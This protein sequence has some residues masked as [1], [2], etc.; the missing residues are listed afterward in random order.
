MQIRFL[1]IAR[2]LMHRKG[3]LSAG[4]DSER[5][6]WTREDGQALIMAGLSMSL[7]IVFMGLA[8]DTGVLFRERRRIQNAADAAATAAALDYH[9]NQSVT[10][11][12]AAGRAAAAA[13]GYPNGGTCPSATATCVAVN[14]PPSSG[15]SH[16]LSSFAEA[17]VNSPKSTGFMGWFGMHSVPVS[18]RAVAGNPAA[19]KGCGFVTGSGASTFKVQGSFEITGSVVSSNTCKSGSA[20]QGCGIYVDSTDPAAVKVTG[21]GSGG[22][23]N[24]NFVDVA[25]GVSGGKNIGP[26]G[27]STNLGNV[28]GD[29]FAQQ[30]STIAQP[31]TSNP[32]NGCSTYITTS[33][34][35]ITSSNITS[36]SATASKPVV[37]F[38]NAVSF[39]GTVNVPGLSTGDAIYIFENGVTFPVGSTVNFGTGSYNASTNTFSSTTGATLELWGGTM[40]QGS[41]S[42]LSIYAPTT[43]GQG[44]TNGIAIWQAVGDTNAL[45][46]QFG[47]NNEVMD[48]FIYAPGADVTLHDSGGGVVATGFVAK[49]MNVGNGQ[50]YLPNYNSANAATTPLTEIILTE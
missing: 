27:I 5:R 17:I 31:T 26:T 7:L 6:N 37:C 9:Y 14:M 45:Q 15:P 41:N 2:D 24:T 40:T 42:I 20:P 39:S 10:S 28:A 30:V 34:L 44:S 16:T 35:T 49:T 11:A 47:S 12:R 36:Y 22:C 29:P 13:N 18:A 21:S 50:L 32:S 1:S 4:S 8:I 33:S 3:S 25:G 46:V 38:K 48:G 19:S 23:L 43:G